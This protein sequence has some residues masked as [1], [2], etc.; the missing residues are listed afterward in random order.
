MKRDNDG[1]MPR[2][3]FHG[4]ATEEARRVAFGEKQFRHPFDGDEGKDGNR[5]DQAAL[6]SETQLALNPGPMAIST[7][8]GGRPARSVWSS[9]NSTVGADILP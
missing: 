3:D 2:R 8:R 7:E 5:A 6:F 4:A 9:T 1:I